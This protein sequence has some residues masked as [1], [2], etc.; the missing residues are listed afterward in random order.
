MR[1]WTVADVMT[2]N[3][4][5]V[6]ANVSYKDIVETLARHRVSAV[7][8]VDTAGHVVGVVSEA[9]L[10]HK[11]ELPGPGGLRAMLERKQRREARDK[12]DG[13]VAAEL[14]TTPPVTVRPEVT[15]AAAARALDFQR[16]KRLPVV[17]GEGRLVGIVSRGDLL[18]VYLREDEAIR[19]EI[20]KQVLLRAL[21]L[22][23]GTVDVAIEHGVVTLTGTADRQ[24]TVEIIG[25]LVQGVAGVV[26]VVNGIVPSYDD[27]ADLHRHHLMGATV[28]ETT[29]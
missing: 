15:V 29:P 2:Q 16:V 23:P 7:P 21:W 3:V 17:D 5:S 9:D 4:V 11:L 13:N 1:R 28:K 24:S 12:A 26:D 19:A 20:E 18:R 27:T 25:R 6:E 8:V 22:E 10:L 14:M